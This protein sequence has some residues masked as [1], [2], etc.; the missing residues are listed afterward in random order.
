[1]AVAIEQN[2]AVSARER[3]PGDRQTGAAALERFELKRQATGQVLDDLLADPARLRA[4]LNWHSL[5]LQPPCPMS[6]RTLS[7]VR[8]TRFKVF[9]TK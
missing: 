3:L 1:M 9:A 8:D 4:W 5:V 7:C 6:P 2:L